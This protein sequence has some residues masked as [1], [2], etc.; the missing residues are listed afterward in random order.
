MQM[1]PMCQVC[2]S[3]KSLWFSRINTVIKLFEY[4]DHNGGTESKQQKDGGQ[5]HD[6]AEGGFLE[7]RHKC[8]LLRL[9]PASMT[10]RNLN[11]SCYNTKIL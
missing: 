6:G 1:W 8:L 11:N 3:P 7:D 9:L 10:L 2:W 4:V 5:E